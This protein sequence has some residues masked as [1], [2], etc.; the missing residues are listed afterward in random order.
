LTTEKSECPGMPRFCPTLVPMR[1]EESG[2]LAEHSVASLLQ[3]SRGILRELR[4]RGVIRS[5]NAPVGDFAEFLT[6]KAT[7]GELAPSSK[8]SWDV[9]T[10][11]QERLQVKARVLTPENT[12]RQLSPIRTWDFDQLV[13]VL[14]DDNFAIVRAAFIDPVLAKQASKWSKH[15]NGWILFA[16]DELL[17]SGLD[18]TADFATLAAGL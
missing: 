3:L 14:F 13:V 10:A 17:V 15:V 8:K 7:Q 5:S 6:A 4:F 1:D 12:S 9:L 16:R 11:G 18:R 2:Q